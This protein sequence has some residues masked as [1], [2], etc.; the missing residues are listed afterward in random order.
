[1]YALAALLQLAFPNFAFAVV[2]RAVSGLTAAALITVSVYYLLQV[3]PPKLRPAALVI[4]IGLTQIGVPLA[5][6][7]PVEMLA[8]DH[9]RN[10][11][12]IE[13]AIR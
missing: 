9:W 8:Q 4:G 1:M 3:F 10:L 5:R 12:L 11:H 6:L 13:L 7:F 2:T